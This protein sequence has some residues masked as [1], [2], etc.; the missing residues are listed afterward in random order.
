MK[1]KHFKIGQSLLYKGQHCIKQAD[2]VIL[3]IRLGKDGFYNLDPEESV[4][5]YKEEPDRK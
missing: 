3:I 4:D 2:N 5:V 1:L